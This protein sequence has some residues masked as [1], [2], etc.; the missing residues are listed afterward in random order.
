MKT[1]PAIQK[2]I[3]QVKIWLNEGLTTGEIQ[4]RFT[5]TY[6][7]FP[8]SEKTIDN[9]I[10]EAKLQAQPLLDES[11]KKTDID[12]LE[13]EK[14]AQKRLH[15]AHLGMV[16]FTAG[17][18]EDILKVMRE[19]DIANNPLPY[20][21]ALKTAQKA[22]LILKDLNPIIRLERGLPN[23]ISKNDNL[24]TEKQYIINTNLNVDETK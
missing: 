7:D 19:Q 10:K 13:R 8:N 16:E 12:I 24:N 3:D 1:K 17:L 23:V 21:T 18:A 14:V 2:Q 11:F 22:G 6:P 4:K 20:L 15:E 9:R 5:Q